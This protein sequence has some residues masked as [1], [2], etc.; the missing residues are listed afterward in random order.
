MTFLYLVR[1]THLYLGLFLLPW[2]IMF[3]VSSI[4]LNHNR[5]AAPPTWNKLAEMPFSAAVPVTNNNQE[6]RGVG[7]EMMNA[8]GVPGGFYVSRP[9]PR[10]INVNHPNFLGPTRI[11]YY[12]DEKRIVAERREFVPRAF[13]T[14]LHTR[15]GYTLGGFWDS[16]WAVF[17]DLLSVGLLLWILS[18]LI[19]WWKIPGTGPRQWGWLALAGGALCFAVI[20]LRL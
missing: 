8:A 4:P 10:Q 15:G 19:M 17:V 1:R 7:R 12:I 14:G 5:P 2:L 9:N 3:G 11:F 16:V 13:I 20:M 6:L 18:G